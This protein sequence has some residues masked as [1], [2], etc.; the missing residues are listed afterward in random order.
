M[1]VTRVNCP[2][3]GQPFSADVTQ[4]FDVGTDPS[5]KQ[6]ILSGAVNIVNCPYC[7]YQGPL[8]TPLV[9]H[10]P[11]K[12][13]LLTFVPPEINLPRPEQERILG[14][15]IQQ[16]VNQLPP[17]KRKAYLLQP[18][19]TLTMQGMLELILEV[20]GITK[21]MIDAQQQRV[22]LIQ[23]LLTITDESLPGVV[24][25]EKELLDSDFFAILS[26]L[27]EATIASGDRNSAQALVDLQRKL[28]PLTEY[29]REIQA[30]SAEIEEAMKTLRELGNGLTREKL[31]ELLI[32]APNEVRLE[33]YVSL[34]RPGL[35]YTF[36]QLLSERIESSSGEEKAKL[37][38]LRGKLL[39]LT[40]EIDKQNERRK[41]VAKANLETLLQVDDIE[42][43]VMQNIQAID[44]YFVEVL[45]QEL[46]AARNAGDLERSAKLGQI[47]EILQRASTPPEVGII[48]ELVEL[49]DA[50][51]IQERLEEIKDQISPEFME[52]LTG[53]IAQ[54]QSQND[55]E[56]ADKLQT[57]YRGAL[58][59][60][61]EANFRAES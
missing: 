54:Y 52:L 58:K 32:D 14:S 46:E 15:I 26:R 22:R 49:P 61:M 25:E 31:L 38:E 9:Y 50:Q 59:M 34:T 19:A 4:L 16:V 37:S 43:A 39:E 48:E 23:R 36:F 5:A 6:L 51:A 56:L 2:N 3:C 7:G 27:V 11:E 10:D 53:F 40:Q 20:D 1:P 57:I 44:E 47:V 30:Q 21:E 55:Q 8:S 24:E 28:L 45:N 13:L 42:T 18:K 29:G 12:E 35:D 60:S 41:E 17:E 33:A